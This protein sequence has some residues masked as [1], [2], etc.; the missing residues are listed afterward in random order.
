M[1]INLGC[2]QNK[3]PGYVNVDKYATVEPDRLCD[4]E[5]FPWPFENECADEIVMTHV[6]EHLGAQPEIFLGIMKELYRVLKPAGQLDIR[7]PH[8]RSDA[9]LGDPTH[10]RAINPAVMDLF[11][12]AKNR[13]W[14]AMGAS[15]SPLA[16]YIDVD[17]ETVSTGYMLSPRWAAK[18]QSG[19]LNN[20]QLAEAEQM[21]NNVAE[22]IHIV[23]RKV[24]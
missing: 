18:H 7:V 23:L 2:G 6:L 9:F 14:K 16:M 10:V 19:E 12:K 4:L 21:Y 22:E 24:A 3:M 11:S 8:P 20:T 17:F 15:N 5:Q 1:K 13:Q